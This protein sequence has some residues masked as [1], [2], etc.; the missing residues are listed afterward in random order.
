[1]RKKL[2]EKLIAMVQNPYAWYN[3]ESFDKAC[4]FETIFR[5]MSDDPCH[6]MH[7]GGR[8]E[9]SFLGGYALGFALREGLGIGNLLSQRPKTYQYLDLF[10]L[11]QCMEVH[12]DVLPETISPPGM[13]P[14]NLVEK[15]QVD[16]S[17]MLRVALGNLAYLSLPAVKDNEKAS[18]NIFQS[19]LPRQTQPSSTQSE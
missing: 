5:Q 13:K 18:D 8:G 17:I 19:S 6:L 11:A 16:N 4:I 2:G 15:V 3:S 9:I 14:R 12:P 1:M 7:V 10:R